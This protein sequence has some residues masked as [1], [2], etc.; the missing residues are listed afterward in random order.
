MLNFYCPDFFNGKDVYA[1]LINWK[2]TY[3][4]VFN[5]DVNIKYIF[6]CLPNMLWNGGGV[7]HNTGC[8]DLAT[9]QE[10]KEFY[11]LLNIH[12]QFTCTNPLVEEKHLSDTYCNTIL[13]EFE[14]QGHEIL[15]SSPILEQY[16]RNTY[17]GYTISRSIVNT[18]T[19]LEWE[20][21]LD[22]QYH[23]I[24][25]PRRHTK[26]FDYLNQIQQQYRNRIE[27][28]CNDPCPIDCPC[29]YSHYERYANH[30]LFNKQFTIDELK[31]NNIK[32]DNLPFRFDMNGLVTYKDI[33]QSYYPLGYTEFKLSGRGHKTTIATSV[34][35]YLI[36]PEYHFL[37]Y[38]FLL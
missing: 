8:V 30:T 28:L 13:K 18:R 10:I 12:L 29:L 16:I 36:K 14:N 35:P 17:P 20:A 3:P 33:L 31:C 6:G 25:L 23:N 38:K 26:D 34:V 5:P 37:A 4:E 7:D 24:V 15:V 22:T 32:L 21:I 2:R 9:M 1:A 11:N 27:I 19:D